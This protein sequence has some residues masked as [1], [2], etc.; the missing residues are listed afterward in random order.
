LE[1]CVSGCFEREKGSG[2]RIVPNLDNTGFV[3]LGTSSSD[4]SKDEMSELIELI[5]AFGANHN[6]ELHEPETRAA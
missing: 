4:L 1:A 2:L 3:N 5:L 6:V